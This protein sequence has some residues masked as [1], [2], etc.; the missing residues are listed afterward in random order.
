MC[1]SKGIKAQSHGQATSTAVSRT[2]S[3][4][5]TE[6]LSPLNTNPLFLPPPAPLT[7]TA[8]PP[9]SI[10]LAAPGIS[11]K[12][13]H[14]TFGFCYWHI[15]LNITSSGSSTGQNSLPFSRPN[16]IPFCGYVSWIPSSVKEHLGCFHRLATADN[17]AGN[18]GVQ[19]CVRGP[20]FDSAGLYIHE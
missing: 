6:S 9:V 18:T 14:A 20:A 19:G 12:G 17:A 16:C 1:S 10:N 15:S 8:L 4:S 7:P 5:H 13:H 11:C 3:L 2:F